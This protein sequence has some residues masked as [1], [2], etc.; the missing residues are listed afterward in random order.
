PPKQP[1]KEVKEIPYTRTLQYQQDQRIARRRKAHGLSRCDS[2][3]DLSVPV[4]AQL[5]KEPPP[6]TSVLTPAP[7]Q[8]KQRRANRTPTISI[9]KIRAPP[10]SPVPSLATRRKPPPRA[11]QVILP[12]ASSPHAVPIVLTHR[13][14]SPLRPTGCSSAPGRPVFPRSKRDVNLLRIA[15]MKRL[16]GGEGGNKGRQMRSMG[17]RGAVDMWR[18]TRELESMMMSILKRGIEASDVVKSIAKKEEERKKA[19]VPG[20]GKALERQ[21]SLVLSNSWV[22]V[23]G[24]DWEMVDCA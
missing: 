9:S 20:K 7:Q 4:A 24:E 10:P 14:T 12:S 8:Q 17:V 18:A 23:P 5:V 16:E 19:Q 6:S 2:V 13:T 22:V 1:S 3:A 15:C 11:P 21:G